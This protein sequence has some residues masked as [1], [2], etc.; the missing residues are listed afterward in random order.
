MLTLSSQPELAEANKNFINPIV[1][2]NWTEVTI[3]SLASQLSGIGRDCEFIPSSSHLLFIKAN[4]KSVLLGDFAVETFGNPPLELVVENGYPELD[5]STFPTCNFYGP[6]PTCTRER[7]LR[8]YS[9]VFF[10]QYLFKTF[11][12]AKGHNRSSALFPVLRNPGLL[13]S[14]ISPAGIGVREYHRS[15]YR[16]GTTRCVPQQAGS[17]VD[18]S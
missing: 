14:C 6:Q 16:R 10:P 11:R 12:N 2:T 3:G 13:Q 1:S 18:L 17:D 7:K 9:L 4:G 15:H 5:N 8:S